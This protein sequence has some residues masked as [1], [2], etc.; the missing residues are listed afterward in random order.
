[1]KPNPSPWHPAAEAWIRTGRP[2]ISEPFVDRLERRPRPTRRRT[3]R[4]AQVPTVSFAA[5]SLPPGD[6]E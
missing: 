5:S 3:K 2:V 1:M 6:R 4:K